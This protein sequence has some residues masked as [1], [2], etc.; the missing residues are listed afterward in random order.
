MRK[1]AILTNIVPPYR[2]PLFNGIGDRVELEVIVCT[3]KE[4]NRKWSITKERKF[5]TKKLFGLTLTLRNNLNDYRFIY[6]KFSIL[7]YLIFHRPYK[8]IIGDASLTSFMAAICCKVLKIDYIWWNET[9]PYTPINQGMLG[10]VR[11]Y[12]IRNAVHH[13]VSGS[14]AKEFIINYGV[15]EGLI[16]IVPDAVDNDKYF[17]LHEL[18]QPQSNEIKSKYGIN[19]DDNTM[20]YVGQFIERKNIQLMLDAYR[21]IYED[22]KCVKFIMVGGG[23]LKDKIFQ[24]KVEHGL[25]GLIVLDFMEPEKLAELYTIANVLILVSNSEPWG[26]VVNEAMCFKVPVILSKYVGAGAD[27]IDNST[28]QIIYDL[29]VST[30]IENIKKIQVM[31]YDGTI[32]M[33][34]VSHWNNSTAVERVIKELK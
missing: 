21:E 10:K 29:N 8:L 26:M 32:I 22:D 20:L 4:K 11:G 7:F 1:I 23:E 25:K 9:L 13:Y 17:D 15:D 2:L 30:L 34:R 24:Y 14:L 18:L 33:N 3:D 31:N 27:L 5:K 12:C 16:T 19:R 6:L 28:G